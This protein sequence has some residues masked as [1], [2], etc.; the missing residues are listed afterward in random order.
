MTSMEGHGGNLAVAAAQ[1]HGVATMWTL[2]GAHVFPLYDA[3]VKGRSLC[4]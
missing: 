3:A 2:S 1:A 4:A